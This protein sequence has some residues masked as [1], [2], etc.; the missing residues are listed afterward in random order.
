MITSI[1]LVTLLAFGAGSNAAKCH[2]VGKGNGC[3]EHP[4]LYSYACV[5]TP[6]DPEINGRPQNNI[7]TFNN[8][9]PQAVVWHC[10]TKDKS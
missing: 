5:P 7:C 2:L 4:Y 3:S 8:I 10:C 1:A 6:D 9:I